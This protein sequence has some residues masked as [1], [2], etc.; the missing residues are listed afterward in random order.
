MFQE[1]MS[2]GKPTVAI[3]FGCARDV[4]ID[5]ETGYLVTPPRLEEIAESILCFRNNEAICYEMDVTAQ[6]HSERFSGQQMVENIA[7]LYRELSTH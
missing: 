4:I 3:D 6:K 1:A 7:S 2:A 5:G